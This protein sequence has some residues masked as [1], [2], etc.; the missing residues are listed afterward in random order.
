VYLQFSLDIVPL[1]NLYSSPDS[2]AFGTYL[3]FI[4]CYIWDICTF[5]L[6]YVWDI[7]ILQLMFHLGY[8]YSAADVV[9]MTE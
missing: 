7:S 3:S 8:L 1:G 4:W 5:H 6:Y 2:V 9:R